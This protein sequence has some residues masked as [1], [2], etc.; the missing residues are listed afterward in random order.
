[1]V[2]YSDMGRDRCTPFEGQNFQDTFPSYIF[3]RTLH[4]V[5]FLEEKA[6]FSKTEFDT[7]RV[8]TNHN[9][10]EMPLIS[11]GDLKS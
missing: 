4:Q 10:T 8:V 6:N 5:S 1:M 3:S 9:E 2:P 11:S 7:Q